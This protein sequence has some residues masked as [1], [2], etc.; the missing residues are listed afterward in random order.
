MN[1]QQFSS[2]FFRYGLITA[3][4][5]ATMSG[6]LIS[7]AKTLAECTSGAASCDRQAEIL[8]CDS[9][10]PYNLA[11][12]TSRI[13]RIRISWNVCQKNDFYQVSWGD[14]KDDV[15]Q[16]DDPTARSW[17]YTGA[18]DSVKYTFKVRGCNHLS[19]Q[20]S[21]QQPDCTAWQELAVTTPDW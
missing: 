2:H 21:T 13:K 4:L 5:F 12:D 19:T 18:R 8:P 3:F 14:S 6:G 10:N 17:I 20:D 9:R 1:K 11:A 16:I 15:A 7:P